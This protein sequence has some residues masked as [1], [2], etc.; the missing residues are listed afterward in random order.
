MCGFFVFCYL[1]I[2]GGSYYIVNKIESLDVAADSDFR[3]LINFGIPIYDWM[4]I[5][6]NLTWVS[7]GFK[8]FLAFI[9]ISSVT[10]EYSDRT[11]R[12]NIIDGLS[13]REW[14]GT[15]FI[16]ISIMSVFAG[17]LCLLLGLFLG[18]MYSPVEGFSYVFTNITFIPA[19]VLEMFA[20]LALA[21]LFSLVIKRT[22]FTIVLFTVLTLFIDMIV[23]GVGTGY[24]KFYMEWLP[25]HAIHDLIH[26]PFAKYGLQP[27]QYH[28]SLEDFAWFTLWTVLIVWGS[29]R[30]LE[31]SDIN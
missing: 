4:D 20:F 10:N 29:I 14:L 1:L 3:F 2:G 15:K 27:W 9:V 13:P 22:G 26:F 5:W 16:M 8:Y 24:Y 7:H 25:F 17:V 6:Q 19:F 12:Q 30:K 23:W 31:R 21:I 11:I 18:F 28:L